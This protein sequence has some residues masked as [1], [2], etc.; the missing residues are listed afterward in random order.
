MRKGEN[1]ILEIVAF[2]L[3]NP[4][5]DARV[6]NGI[7]C[8]KADLSGDIPNLKFVI[9]MYDTHKSMRVPFSPSSG[10]DITVVITIGF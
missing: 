3:E 5:L 4:I 9:K 10:G 6:V 7:T 2:D 1:P 8:L